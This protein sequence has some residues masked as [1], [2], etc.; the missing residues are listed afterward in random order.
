MQGCRFLLLETLVLLWHRL[1]SSVLI[2]Q[3]LFKAGNMVSPLDSPVG[4][5]WDLLRIGFLFR[6]CELPFPNK[7]YP[8]EI[9]EGTPIDMAPQL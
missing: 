6:F 9:S 8:S 4:H 3:V 5:E 1:Q 7:E 2:E